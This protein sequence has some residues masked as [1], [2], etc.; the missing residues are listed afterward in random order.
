MKKGTRKPSQASPRRCPHAAA[1]CTCAWAHHRCNEKS[2]SLS[3][4]VSAHAQAHPGTPPVPSGV[5]VKTSDHWG[6][7]TRLCRNG[8]VVALQKDR[9]FCGWFDDCMPW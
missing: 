1:C 4:S 2:L 6:S 8:F 3:T 5:A 9:F 7:S